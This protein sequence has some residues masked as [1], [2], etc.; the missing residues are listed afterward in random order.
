MYIGSTQDIC[1]RQRGHIS[2]LQRNV[3]ANP[4]FQRAFNKYGKDAVLFEVLLLCDIEY[5]IVNEQHF[6]N[7]L[8]PRYNMSPV[9]GSIRG[10]KYSDKQRAARS[11]LLKA[12]WSSK[13]GRAKYK[14]ALAK[15]HKARLATMA[16]KRE[17][18]EFKSKHLAGTRAAKEKRSSALKAAWRDPRKRAKFLACAQSDAARA[19]RSA[20]LKATLNRPEAKQRYKT[21]RSDPSFLARRNAAIKAGWA[22]RLERIRQNE[23]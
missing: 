8:K 11:T 6:I 1:K 16:L 10:F 22:K 2:A 7:L 17:T 3:H 13:S 20:S 14:V 12:R 9:S 21:A 5:L 15:S 18:Q 19:K 4:A 23:R